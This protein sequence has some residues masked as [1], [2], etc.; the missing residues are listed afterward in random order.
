MKGPDVSGY[1]C[2]PPVSP[3][4]V[5]RLTGIF[6]NRPEGTIIY[7]FNKLNVNTFVNNSVISFNDHETVNDHKTVNNREF[8]ES[9]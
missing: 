3:Y 2:N 4:P 5:Q 6:F 8:N 1:I 9:M 7:Y